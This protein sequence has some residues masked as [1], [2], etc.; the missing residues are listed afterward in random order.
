MESNFTDVE[1]PQ[2]NARTHFVELWD[3]IEQQHNIHITI[4]D[5]T[6]SLLL[7][8][9]NMLRPQ[10]NI[11]R[12]KYCTFNRQ[13]H[14]KYC[15]DHCHW[16][17]MNEAARQ[18]KPFVSCCHAGA[19]ELVMPLMRQNEHIATIFAGTFRSAE[20]DL[21]PSWPAQQKNLYS[22]M[23]IWHQSAVPTLLRTL[24][25]F[26]AAALFFAEN[27]RASAH[28]QQGRREEI[29]DF[30]LRCSVNPG[31]TLTDLAE[32]LELSLSRTSHV[33]KKEFNK[34]FNE[35]LNAARIKRAADLLLSTPFS[36][37]HIAVLSGFDNEYYFNRVFK[38]QTGLPPG[39]YRK[40]YLQKKVSDI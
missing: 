6:G 24:E 32:Q 13:R 8:D 31:L 39:E 26:G 23:N 10:G 11:H 27:E 28:S 21:P 5:H 18:G 22:D 17:V 38:R 33:L 29:K 9:G 30:F 15:I 1:L 2:L 12:C 25:Q 36:L 35:L 14:L 37:K 7:S 19:M 34:N 20:L 40:K 3:S 4:H 16:Q